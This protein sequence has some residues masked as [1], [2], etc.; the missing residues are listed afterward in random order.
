L[1]QAPLRRDGAKPF[2]EMELIKIFEYLKSNNKVYYYLVLTLYGFGLRIS[3]ALSLLPDDI[4]EKENQIFVRVRADISKFNKSREAPLILKGSY[5]DD[6]VRFLVDRKNPALKN[7]TLFTYYNDIQK[8]IVVLNI[9][10]V[11]NYF[12]KLSKQLDVK[13]TAH[14]FRDTYISYMIAKGI[15]PIT[16]A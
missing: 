2:S 1:A 12:H 11:K 3:E 7:H 10:A 9:E 5:R 6:Y 16:V 13:I 15:K 8:R 4:F 14:R